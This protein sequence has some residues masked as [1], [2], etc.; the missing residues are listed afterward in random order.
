MA[1][2]PRPIAKSPVTQSLA[3]AA[4][5]SLFFLPAAINAWAAVTR[6]GD[7]VGVH[8]ISTIVLAVAGFGIWRL[9]SPQHRVVSWLMLIWAIGLIAFWLGSPK[10]E[11]RSGRMVF[12]GML[13]AGVGLHAFDVMQATGAVRLRQARQLA[14]RLM[15][16]RRWP[17]DLDSCRQLPE[18]KALREAIRDEA[19]PVLE[20]LRHSSPS[21]R[22]AGLAA[23]ELRREWRPGQPEAVLELAKFDPNPEIRAAALWALGGIQQRLIVE[24]MANGLYDSSPLVRQA[25]LDAL[26]WDCDQR[27]IWVRHAVHQA[28][29][30][31]RSSR[32]GPLVLTMGRFSE[33]AAADLIAWSTEAGTL[34]LRATQ[35]LARHYGQLLG[36][37]HD[38][39]L[40]AHLIDLVLSTRTAAILRLELASLL[41]QHDILA[42]D[43]L[44]RLLDPANP[45][46]LRL[47]AVE[48]LLQTGPHPQA[49]EALREVARHPNRELA[50][51]AALIVQRCLH[52]DMG[53]ALDQPLPPLHTR[54]A[55]DV[56]RRVILWAEQRG[57]N[58]KR[59]SSCQARASGSSQTSLR[60]SALPR[61]PSRG[62]TTKET[63]T[64]HQAAPWEWD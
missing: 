48:S 30:D 25:A 2:M 34:G 53:L 33:A 35:T 29:G 13:L 60:D 39:K 40:L 5:F 46:S 56:T 18:V 23:L 1:G 64:T 24:E 15:R 31:P 63:P 42:R 22:I 20:M 3:R 14:R 57:E 59:G 44:E 38:P 47:L 8:F 41:R 51:Q 6:R 49:I 61:S 11:D 27:W 4:L 28:L 50:M 16:R 54:Q 17:E 58:P 37:R 19:G 26:L 7:Y 36:E 43:A 21:V 32:D 10:Q 9:M 12:G 55:A 52:V 62:P 45:S